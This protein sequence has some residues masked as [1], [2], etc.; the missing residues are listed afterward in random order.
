MLIKNLLLFML[1]GLLAI[2]CGE[3]GSDKDSDSDKETSSNDD[4]AADD[5]P[6]VG[7]LEIT[8]ASDVMGVTSVALNSVS[9]GESFGSLSASDL[10]PGNLQVG[11]SLVDEPD[12]PSEANPNCSGNG[13]PYDASG[14]ELEHGDEQYAVKKFYCLMHDKESP[15]VVLGAIGITRGFICVVE[16]QEGVEYTEAGTTLDIS[17]P[18]ILNNEVAQGCFPS[19][20][21]ES[22]E[23]E[24]GR[25]DYEATATATLLTSGKWT[26]K[27]EMETEEGSQ[28]TYFYIGDDKVA[29][30]SL[31]VTASLDFENGVLRFENIETEHDR[32]TRIMVTG[33]LN[34][35]GSFESQS[36]M[37]GL[38]YQSG[39]VESVKGTTDSGYVFNQ[40][41]YFEDNWTAEGTACIGG[42]ECSAADGIVFSVESDAEFLSTDADENQPEIDTWRDD[43]GP[44]CFS[45]VAKTL[46]PDGTCSF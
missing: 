39:G 3:A 5:T 7:T 27:L 15:D 4:D 16:A 25:M 11:S 21:L 46:V 23:E 41:S 8:S 18:D 28:V 43:H 13:V 44:L 29:F 22:S 20:V 33:E 14:N 45:S 31:D 37:E 26:H 40:Y 17:I 2:S 24:N 30:K 36:A 9:E 10:S 34:E 19:Q 6:D 38:Q 42:D 1:T 35:E 12:G 32:H